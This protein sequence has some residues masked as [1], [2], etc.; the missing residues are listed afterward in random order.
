MSDYKANNLFD[1][2][3]KMFRDFE[4]QIEEAI[5][6][7]L[8]NIV[9][10]ILNIFEYCKQNNIENK[11]PIDPGYSDLYAWYE[12]IKNIDCLLIKDQNYKFLIL[13]KED[14][15]I[16]VYELEYL[17]RTKEMK[18]SLDDFSNIV[19]PSLKED[20]EKWKL[21]FNSIENGKLCDIS[22][23]DIGTCP[24]QPII[25]MSYRNFFSDGE[26]DIFK[27]VIIKSGFDYITDIKKLNSFENQINQ[28]TIFIKEEN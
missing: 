8:P 18:P 20:D 6:N 5:K 15:T 2:T 4:R 21:F 17:Y 1:A 24:I 12:T 11:N 10:D 16:C 14:K 26:M 23:K 19:I 9:P 13:K 27:N 22:L 28:F 25:E 7:Y 3:S